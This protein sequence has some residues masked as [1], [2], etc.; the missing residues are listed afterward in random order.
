VTFSADIEQSILVL[1]VSSGKVVSTLAPCCSQGCEWPYAQKLTGPEKAEI[2]SVS[3]LFC[4]S[5]CTKRGRSDD[6]SKT[7][8]LESAKYQLNQLNFH[9]GVLIK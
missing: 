3:I 2:H 5:R 8:K 9:T 1:M 4:K 7:K 6:R